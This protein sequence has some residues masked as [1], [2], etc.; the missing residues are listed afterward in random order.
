MCSVAVESWFQ[1]GGKNITTACPTTQYIEKNI[2][3]CVFSVSTGR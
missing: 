3:I 1:W 2:V